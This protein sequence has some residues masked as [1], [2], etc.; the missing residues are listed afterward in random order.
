MGAF[1]RYVGQKSRENKPTAAASNLTESFDP[2]LTVTANIRMVPKLDR[3]VISNPRASSI[4]KACVRQLVLG[5]LHRI[6]FDQPVPFRDQVTFG[7]GE[8]LHYWVQNTEWLW[9]DSRRVGWWHCRGCNHTRLFGT[10]PT[11][12]CEVCN[13]LPEA[14]V[15]SEHFM[16]ITRKLKIYGNRERVDVAILS[17]HPDLF[18]AKDTYPAI[19]VNELKSISAQQFPGLKAP[20]ADHEH[21]VITYMNYLNVDPLMP[22]PVDDQVG[23]VT[24]ISKKHD[25]R[26]IPIKMF[27]VEN[28]GPIAERIQARVDEYVR[29]LRHYPDHL[30]PPCDECESKAFGNYRAKNCPVRDKCIKLCRK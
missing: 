12:K 8:A 15:Y 4:L 21:Q 23:Y 13:A 24:Y 7:V 9:P 27:P 1:R 22:A 16:K 18:L 25:F 10:R 19:R 6:Q 20:L 29:G 14:C 2:K 11:T 30:P 3:K 5:T 26:D 28:K 17:G